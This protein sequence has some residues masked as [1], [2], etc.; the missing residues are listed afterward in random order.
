MTL[1]ITNLRQKVINQSI[2]QNKY[3]YIYIYIHIKLV[4]RS[5]S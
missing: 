3:I 2:D 1:Q 4:V 5:D